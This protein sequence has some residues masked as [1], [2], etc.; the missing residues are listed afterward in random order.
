[1][2]DV[3]VGEGDIEE[4]FEAELT[5][6]YLDA[7]SA[8]VDLK[9]TPRVVVDAGNAVPGKYAPS[10][11]KRIGCDVTELFCDLDGSFPNH[12]PDPLHDPGSRRDYIILYTRI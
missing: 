11:L 12:L 9:S 6:R 3:W 10:L 2:H 8:R 7:I 1:M 5:T 4:G